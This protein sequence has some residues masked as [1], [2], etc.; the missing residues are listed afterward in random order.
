MPTMLAAPAQRDI[1]VAHVALLKT[2][3]F[4]SLARTAAAAPTC[5]EEISTALARAGFMRKTVPSDTQT[6]VSGPLAPTE[7]HVSQNRW[8]DFLASAPRALKVNSAKMPRKALRP[9]QALLPLQL[10][11]SGPLSLF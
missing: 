10:V 9:L 6:H 5:L 4:P 7:A 3:V 1:L 2:R 11:L 8:E